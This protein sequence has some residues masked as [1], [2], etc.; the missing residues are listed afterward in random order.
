M[1]IILYEERVTAVTLSSYIYS[2]YSFLPKIE[3]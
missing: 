3:K 2:G 1:P